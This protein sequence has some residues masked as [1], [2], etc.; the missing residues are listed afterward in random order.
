[1]ARVPALLEINANMRQTLMYHLALNL[2]NYLGVLPTY[3]HYVITAPPW[4]QGLA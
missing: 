1:M 2:R 3:L 4:Y